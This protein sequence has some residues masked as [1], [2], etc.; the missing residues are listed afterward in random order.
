VLFQVPA[1]RRGILLDLS[2]ELLRRDEEAGFTVFQPLKQE[3]GAERCFTG[4]GVPGDQCHGMRREATV[5]KLIEPRYARCDAIDHI[6]T[7]P[8]CRYIAFYAFCSPR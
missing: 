8:S 4:P 5:D 6:I 3:L 2:R 1:E 7:I